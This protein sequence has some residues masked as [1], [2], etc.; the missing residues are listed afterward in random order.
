MALLPSPPH[1]CCS[2]RQHT[3]SYR[4]ALLHTKPFCI[5]SLWSKMHF[6]HLRFL[7]E[8]QEMFCSPGSYHTWEILSLSPLIQFVHIS[9]PLAICLFLCT[10]CLSGRELFQ[11]KV[12]YLILTSCKQRSQH[13]IGSQKYVLNSIDIGNRMLGQRMNL[14]TCCHS[15]SSKRDDSNAADH[16][17]KKT[18]PWSH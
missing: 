17:K 11:A 18:F 7:A 8:I 12:I 2:R 3:G 13:I 10:S 1:C 5:L 9:H 15:F 16:L 14:Y 4:S 6:P